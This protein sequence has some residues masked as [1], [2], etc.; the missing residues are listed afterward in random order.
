MVQPDLFGLHFIDHY[1]MMFTD[2]PVSS[3]KPIGVVAVGTTIGK[4]IFDVDPRTSLHAGEVVQ[5]KNDNA[6][7]YYQIVGAIINEVSL[8]ENNASQSVKVTAGQLGLWAD[9]KATFDPIDWVAAAGEVVAI[10]RGE[11]IGDNL[12]EGCCLI[13]HVPNSKFPVHVNIADSIT[14]NTALI[15]VTGSGK[16]YLAFHLIESYITSGIINSPD[17]VPFISSP[18]ASPSRVMP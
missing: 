11:G 14:H 5:V 6:N 15:G 8:T 3:E 9:T 7:S 13:G 16:S 12:P 4:L 1:G 2:A 10:S 17:S 18:S